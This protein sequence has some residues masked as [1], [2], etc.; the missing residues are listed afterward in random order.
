MMSTKTVNIV[1]MPAVCFDNPS[2]SSDLICSCICTV[3]G[4]GFTP[5]HYCAR[6]GHAEAVALL[7]SHGADPNATTTV[8]VQ[9]YHLCHSQKNTLLGMRLT[10]LSFNVLPCMASDMIMMRT[11]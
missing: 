7:L 3:Q 11:R 10:V 4:E 5:L 8:M 2:C 9:E 6:D 1:S